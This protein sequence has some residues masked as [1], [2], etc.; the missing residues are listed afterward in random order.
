MDFEMKKDIIQEIKKRTTMPSYVLE[1]RKD[2]QPGLLDSKFG[3]IPYWDM[4]REYPA[5]SSGNKLLFLAQINL[6]QMNP[7]RD[8]PGSGMLQ[9]FTGLDDVFGLDFDNQD[10]QDTFRVIYHK[11]INS[12][13]TR[14]QVE[15]LN[16]PSAADGTNEEYT[17]VLKESAV[18]IV[19]KNDCMGDSDYRFEQ[20]FKTIAREKHGLDLRQESLYEIIGNEDYKKLEDEI[21]S[22]TGHRM[23]GYPFFTQ[24][25]PR[26][27]QKR[28][29]YY[30]TL[31][32]QIDSDLI[33][34]EDYVIWGDCGVGNFFINGE[35]LQRLD[36]S[37]ILYNWDCC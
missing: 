25:D 21:H 8:F 23:L 28:Y 32:L 6:E 34:G 30:D 9:F 5:D 31:L 10:N 36:F 13:I 24:Y 29:E 33:D 11:T 35:D 20:L 15:S 27:G 1:I 18:D 12:S 3:G 17:P 14:A 19:R 7:E 16:I 22:D 2:R 4:S 26:G 37:K